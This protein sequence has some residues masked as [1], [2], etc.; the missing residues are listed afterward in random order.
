M[1]YELTWDHPQ[2]HNLGTIPLV[3]YF[4]MYDLYIESEDLF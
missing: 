2:S 4:D 1:W 3:R